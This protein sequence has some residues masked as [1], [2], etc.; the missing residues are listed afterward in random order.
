[1]Q[2]LLTNVKEYEIKELAEI[3]PIGEQQIRNYRKSG[4]LKATKKRNRWFIKKEDLQI[5]CNEQG[6]TKVIL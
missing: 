5:F 6:F 2:P 1:M 4:A 3:L